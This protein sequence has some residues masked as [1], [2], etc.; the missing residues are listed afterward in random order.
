MFYPVRSPCKQV[1][2]QYKITQKSHRIGDFDSS[3][4]SNWIRPSTCIS[5]KRPS[6]LPPS[7]RASERA[8]WEVA[9][10]PPFTLPPSLAALSLF[11]PRR[12]G[13]FGVGRST[14]YRKRSERDLRLVVSL[15]VCL[16][17]CHKALTR[18]KSRARAI[19]VT[20]TW[21]IRLHTVQSGAVYLSQ[22]FAD[23]VL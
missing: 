2:Y 10:K 20:K 9:D 4:F 14:F 15:S 5:S 18:D 22:G 3:F 13:L 8:R 12:G 16:S 19:L 1:K 11:P 6:V 17:V 21:P 7:E 23:H